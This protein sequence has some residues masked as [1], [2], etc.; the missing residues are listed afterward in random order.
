M[1]DKYQK[2]I[3]YICI[4]NLILLGIFGMVQASINEELTF[5]GKLQNS[6]GTNVTDGS[7][8]MFFKIYTVA[9]SGTAIYTETW[10]NTTPTT[11]S[12][13][14]NDTT[15]PQTTD[16]YPLEF[17]YTDDSSE[18]TLKEGQTLYNLT[19]KDR[20]EITS[21]GSC[22]QAID[23]TNNTI[24][25]T[26]VGVNWSDSDSITTKPMVKDGIFSVRIGSLDPTGNNLLT[27]IA[28]YLN[29]DLWLG[30]QVGSD[31]SE[32][33]PRKKLGSVL[34]ALASAKLAGPQGETIDN[35]TDDLIK[36]IGS[37]G[38][39]NTDLYINLDGTYPTLYS[40]TDTQI[41]IDDDLIFVGAK[42]LATSSGALTIQT[43]ASE[44]AD[45]IIFQLAGAE[46]MRILEN[47]DLLFEKGTYDTTLTVTTPTAN[48]T[49]AFPDAE[50]T[51]ALGTGTQDYATYWSATSTIAAEQYLSVSRGGTGAGTLNDLITLGTHTAGNYVA[52]AEGS[53]PIQVSGSGVE[54]AAI[55]IS[56][57]TCITSTGGGTALFTLAGSS[58]TPQT[59]SA[60]DTLTVEAGTNITTTAAATDKVTVAT[61]ANPTFS[62]SVT[63][64][65]INLTDS[66]NQIV[67][68]SDGTYTG[69]ITMA[70]LGASK[71]W[72][73][74]DTTGTLAL[75]TGT[76]DYAT[77][78][79]ATSTIAAEQYLSV[80]R[81][82]TGRGSWTQYGV[83]YADTT[84][85]LTNTAAGTAGQVLLSGGA[86]SP[87]YGTL[88]LTYGGTA[89]DLSGAA[90]GGVIY[91]G[92]TALAGSAAG[93]SGYALV[94]GGTGAPTW[95]NTPSWSTITLSTSVTT[96]LVTNAGILTL[97]T[98]TTA[99]AD[100]IIFQLAGTEK[101]RIL[102]NGDLFF[103]KGTYDTTLTVTTPTA[104][105]T[106]T[107][108]DAEGTLALGTGT[109]DY[110]AY[111]S[112]TSTIA[113]EQYLSVSRGGTGAGTLNDLITLGT[114]TAGNYVATAEGSSPIQ[115]SGSGTETAAITISCPTC[116]TS[117]G[118][119]TTLFTLAGTSGTSQTISTGDTLT[120]EAGTNITTTAAATDKVTVATVA[121]PTF[122]TSVTSPTFRY[123]GSITIDAYNNLGNSTINLTNTDATYV[124]NV[125]IEGDLTVGG[126]ISSGSATYTNFTVTGWADFQG[127]IY[128]TTGN[129]TLA[130]TV[131]V[132]QSLNVSGTGT[133]TFAGTFD[134]DNVAAFTLTGNITGSGSP[135]ITGIGQFSGSTAVLS[136]SVTTPLLT[137][138]SGALTIQTGTS[139]GAD[140]IIFQ[141]AG[142]EKMRIEEDG[143]L[144][145]EKG[146][147]DLTL[148]VTAPSGA[149]RTL[150][151]PAL[152]A[153]GNLAVYSGSLAAGDILYGATTNVMGRL[154]I[155]SANQVLGVVGGAGGSLEYKTISGTG[156]EIDITHAANSIT[157]G[158]VDPLALSKGGTSKALTASNGGIVYTDAD[159]MEIL[160]GTA[161]AGQILRSGVS[162]APSWSTATYP[163]TATSAGTILR[164]DGTNWVASTATYPNTVSI[165]QA[166]YATGA[167]VIGA[168]TLP[169]A[170]GGTGATTFT[171]Y[172]V[173]YGN[174]ASAIG[175]TAAGSTGQV[176]LATSSAAPSWGT[177]G[178]AQ[179]TDNSL[180][181]IDF[182]DTLDLDA[183][184][185]L[186][187]STYTWT[188]SFTGSGNAFSLSS[189]SATA[190]NKTLNISQTG[191]TTGIDYGIYVSNTGTSTTNIGLYVTAYNATDNYAA[192]FDAGYVG[193]GTAGPRSAL[194]T[195]QGVM[196]G[197]ANDYEKAQFTMSGG[198][199]ITWG[200]P[201]G[202]LKWTQRIIAS[203]VQ[204][205]ETASAGYIEIVQPTTDIPAG[206]VY[207]GSARSATADGVLLNASEALYAVHTV[208]GNASAITY[209]I[210]RYTHA[211][212]PPSNWL[213]VAAVNVDDSTVK[214]GTGV[215]LK[216]GG[217]WSAGTDDQYVLT[218]GDTMT[219]TLTFSGV[220]TDITTGANEHLALMPNGNGNVGIGDTSPLAL[221]TVGSGDLF[222][223]NSSG[224]IVAATG[225]TS[226]GTITFS[227]LAASRVVLT[228]TGGQLITSAA[229]TSG[230]ALLSGGA[231]VPSWGTLGLTYGGTN[232]SLTANNGGIVYSTDSALAI[233]SGTATANKM[234]LSG[235]S[236][237]PTWSTSTIPSSAGA[238]A[239]KFL[240]SDGANYVL[241]TTTWPDASATA[242]KFIRS[243]GTNWIASTPTL[244]TTAGTVNTFLKSDGTN[245][246]NS[247]VTENAGALAAV[248]TLS[249]SSQ[250][251]NSYANTAALNLTGAGAGITFT[252]TGPNQIITAAAVN[253]ALMP[254][255][256]GN[257]GIG[258]TSPLALLHITKD[259]DAITELR[260]DNTDATSNAGM[261]LT[262]YD[263]SNRRGFLEYS[264]SAA[265]LKLSTDASSGQLKLGSGLAV[266]AVT[267]D[268][269]GNVGI[270]TDPGAVK[271]NVNNTD[272]G[273]TGLIVTTAG[274][275]GEI[276]QGTQTGVDP[277][278]LILQATFSPS[279]SSTYSKDLD[280]FPNIQPGSGVVITN[281]YGIY[282]NSGNQAGAGSVTNG[283][284][285]YVGNPA[286]G[287]NKYAAYFGGNV[288]IGTTGP[289]EKLVVDNGNII[290]SDE[291]INLSNF[292][293]YLHQ[294]FNDG[295]LPSDFS[296]SQITATYPEPGSIIKLEATGGDPMLK[297][298]NLSIDGGVYRYIV[299]KLRYV[300]GSTSWQGTTYYSTT[301]GASPHG[302]SESYKQTYSAP[303]SDGSW[304]TY[305]LDMWNLTA[306]GTDWKDNTVTQI[307]NDWANATGGIYELD[308]IAIGS[309]SSSPLVNIY[310]KSGNVGINTPSPE[311]AV[312]AYP[313]GGSGAGVFGFRAFSDTTGTA[314][315]F[316]FY[317]ARG[318]ATVPTAVL[319]G[320]S[321]GSVSARP[322]NGT[323]FP[324]GVSP[325]MTFIATE[326]HSTTARGDQI[327]FRTTP[328]GS[329]TRADRLTIDQSGNV[330]I[331]TTT[332][333][334][335]IVGTYDWT[336]GNVLQLEGGNQPNLIVRGPVSAELSLID[337][338]GVADEKWVRWY[339]EGGN[340]ILQVIDDAGT[341]VYNGISMDNTNRN[342]GIG[343][344]APAALLSVGS[345]SQFQVSSA[346]AI[347]APT[348]T[349]TINN[350]IINA[351][352]LS[353]ITTLSMNNQLTNTLAIGTA[354]F[355]I[356][357]TNKVTNLN[358]DAV[359]D[360]HAQT[361][362]A[363]SP[364]NLSGTTSV[365]AAA[366]ITISHL[367][368][369]GNIHL[370]TGGSLNQILK[371]SGTSGTGAWGTV[372]ENAGALA[373]ITTLSMNNQLT[374]TLAIGTAPMVIT[375]T[376]K[377]ANLN[378]DAIDD[379]HISAAVSATSP[380]TITANA[381]MLH[382]TA[383]TAITIA[384][385]TSAGNIHLPTGGS[386]NQI[387]KNSGT[388]G[389]GA[390]GTVTENA[391]AL[392][393]VTSLTLS[394]AISGGTTY[395]GSGNIT[396]TAGVLTISG[397]GNSSF[398]GNV[399]IGVTGPGEKLEVAGGLV[400]I[401]KATNVDNDSPGIVYASNDD[402]LY[403]S[404]YI[405]H[406][407]FGFHDPET[408]GQT[409]AYMSG[410]YGIDLFT[411]GSNRLHIDYDGNV[412][413]GN[414]GPDTK[415][416]V[417]GGVCIDTDDVCT[418]PGAGNLTVSGTGNS[419]F[420]GN[421]GVEGNIYDIS[422][423]VLT[424][425]DDLDVAGGDITSANVITSDTDA[426][427]PHIVLDST[428]AGDNWTS[429][430]AYISIG[431][432]GNLGAA[433]L[434]MTYV[435]DGYSYI[436][437]G[438]VTSGIP[439]ASYLRFAYNTDN[440]YTPDTLTVGDL[441]CTDCI[442]DTE[443]TDIYVFNTSDTMSGSL[444]VGTDLT[445][446]GSGGFG[447]IAVNSSV[448]PNSNT[449]ISAGNTGVDYQANSGWPSTW[450]SNILLSG[451]DYTS[452][453]FHDSG[454]SVGALTYHANQFAFDG[455]GSWGPVSLGINDR[456]PD[457]FLDITGNAATTVFRADDS[458]EGDTTPFIILNNGS[459][460]IGTTGPGAKF[461]IAGIASSNN[462][463]RFNVTDAAAGSKLF[464][465]YATGGALVFRA[466]ADD[467]S[468]PLTAYQISRVGANITGHSWKIGTTPTEAMSINSSGNLTMSGTT[469]TAS[470][471]ATLTTAATF[472][473]AAS[474]AVQINGG[475][476]KLTVL[477]VDPV[478]NIDGV[479]YATYMAAMTGVKEETAGVI[480]VKEQVEGKNYFQYVIDF[481][482]LET[483]SDLWL[484]S[485]TTNLK[486]NIDKLVVLLTPAGNVKTWYQIDPLQN[487]LIVYASR[488]TTISYRL[489][490]P[491][492]DWQEWGNLAKDT[493]GVEGMAINDSGSVNLDGNN[494]VFNEENNSEAENVEIASFD[495]ASIVQLI[496]ESIK[497]VL[498]SL[499]GTIKAAG[500]WVFDK[501]LVKTAEIENLEVKKGITIYDK[502]TGEPYC[503]EMEDGN[504]VSRKGKCL[505]EV[506]PILTSVSVASETPVITET[507]GA[508]ETP[509]V[510]ETT[511]ETPETPV[512]ESTSPIEPTPE[513]T[514]ESTPTPEP[515]SESLPPTEEPASAP[516]GASAAEPPATE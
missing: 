405:N 49:I 392:A 331:G 309:D 276:F 207:D 277:S 376:T 169:V 368:T 372:T 339:N 271:L 408:A 494:Y 16:T 284:G 11:F 79:S 86:G 156:S 480:N 247:T 484:F 212:N 461:E 495:I 113:A 80:S 21:G 30:V 320:N 281:A 374:N 262:L 74:P 467:G 22:F 371:N 420:A 111:W 82:G 204:R 343:T 390:W 298:T 289:T 66:T 429:Q 505:E 89:A 384:H 295:S 142:A 160:D 383:G 451:A 184:L 201:G 200:G 171:Q 359:D 254:G 227:D 265:I 141:L 340:T 183:N 314:G 246:V 232:A 51:L 127:D 31:P 107:F 318:T 285:L 60:G 176:L 45:D 64:P 413:I 296:L 306:G 46:K 136:T 119:G 146:T 388:S 513:L 144:F 210:V 61:V 129:L 140:D 305:V 332:P 87:S 486:Q 236:G 316:V 133:H 167:D 313:V 197:A 148:S 268:S 19:K 71:V 479:K 109:A 149:S 96:P 225:I 472:N 68:D 221:L 189:S 330:G 161:T 375:S 406:Y 15:P 303:P 6:D 251:T 352:A 436:G 282:V 389:T 488:P 349:N 63:T 465:M 336:A 274:Q 490:A 397:T 90:Q 191:A 224:A 422:Q 139:T 322:Y 445:V 117:T 291:G 364:I 44:G 452:I 403:N 4:V 13:T 500:E 460:G 425:D 179:V 226:S 158:I 92:A 185:T 478:Y 238:T 234:L 310:E 42:T 195:Y 130:D 311:L 418:D 273:V 260:I 206:Q 280:I 328:N 233:L 110:A 511:P 323:T 235:A 43:G 394:G 263:G 344:A 431:E 218:A 25:I 508:P 440:I 223:V 396:S 180:D 342:V 294:D 437:S 469:F 222:Q 267:I 449:N 463:I 351:G 482:N 131:D 245:W 209:Y 121:N 337:T 151:I 293:A 118:G 20:V 458:G 199:T 134:P 198:G 446:T 65:K 114:H 410:Y 492:F 356:T 363:T 453:A 516:D 414:T 329:I 38:T 290:I 115:V 353:G 67:L 75:G 302:E 12:S 333:G 93:T 366:G 258:E 143:D 419:T 99:G 348:S 73:L 424:I 208:G 37:G 404:L 395:S 432:S 256:T 498:A 172:G 279:A 116:V 162:S 319:S 36:I 196:T 391:G 219:G 474:T 379:K 257:V 341:T 112:A 18:S 261:A 430:G 507:T 407:G 297:W 14:I 504:L 468:L 496:K 105:R 512:L 399:G 32:M 2:I 369:A 438:A 55:T 190:Y 464:E 387:L 361:L 421:L 157:I 358:V 202:R 434:H 39:D 138:S 365:L 514:P 393:A 475:A 380:I 506:E 241:T 270:G 135:N 58:G 493:E 104:N 362:T 459:V 312:D 220:A 29:Q 466:P 288:G 515:A 433:A 81:G 177:V 10:D 147:Y 501:I 237:A 102:E 250:L 153:D 69:T 455:A 192:I 150:T 307:R 275:Y 400:K 412:G 473:I 166:L 450:N 193:I 88:G 360:L 448:I 346:G 367:T 56:C 499:T 259:Q 315:A 215:T 132:Q 98:T 317:R 125:T 416:H 243:D 286:F 155:G 229:G 83:L 485:K 491:R 427:L 181:F 252:G 159:S 205:P 510:I 106:I 101:M 95:T 347:T 308:W 345:T 426:T 33:R 457:A 154:T 442:N 17:T 377:V 41:G 231:S 85:S 497:E 188:Q 409:G 97:Q 327:V 503:V 324:S 502:K 168:G 334:T 173:L 128:D 385:D 443:I 370:P 272:S 462:I 278:G 326:D 52:T 266:T 24:C 398:V 62:T 489:T 186:N 187:Q 9:E 50:G 239:D 57:P 477:T 91:K 401:P 456:S 269:T 178:S 120:V 487:K 244:P 26:K 240:K 354:P 417:T 170:A 5:Q 249:M 338:G 402:F 103:E 40:N 48:R 441:S 59:I 137:T 174:A 27:T 211:F 72:T 299:F 382:A 152:G 53:S 283:Y 182:E 386:L 78:W 447:T 373:A 164:A 76:Q 439:G 255:T 350:L 287:T 355:V 7:Y 217:T 444:G 321:L 415:L 47:G 335:D 54:T 126:G 70:T 194:D 123:D 230:Q 35:A 301:G 292:G 476:G 423:T 428:G 325:M 483:G 145:F 23:T 304:R 471:L 77:Y 381:F 435:G 481:N 300:S 3:I 203:P 470:S 28:S 228:T 163:A 8:N 108:P 454:T 253:L 214:L 378:V 213:L 165:N 264:T 100:D 84:G 216:N 1:N 124:A 357:S 509:E 242:G 411:S 122:S 175:V 248:T 94:S 34:W